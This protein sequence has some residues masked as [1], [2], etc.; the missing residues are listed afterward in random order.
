ML[1]YREL[2]QSF[3]QALGQ[4]LKNYEEEQLQKSSQI[5]PHRQTDIN[6]ILCLIDSNIDNIQ[7]LK[8]AIKAQLKQ[9]KTGIHVFHLFWIQT[10]HSK[11]KTAVIEVLNDTNHDEA[12][13]LQAQAR[14]LSQTLLKWPSEP[15]QPKPIQQVEDESDEFQL[16]ST[17]L[18]QGQNSTP[19]ASINSIPWAFKDLLAPIDFPLL[20]RDKFQA[21]ELGDEVFEQIEKHNQQSLIHYQQLWSRL[22]ELFDENEQLRLQNQR[23]AEKNQQ[24]QQI[25]SGLQAAKS[26]SGSMEDLSKMNNPHQSIK[27]AFFSR[28]SIN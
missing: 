27:A 12:A 1:N 8:V 10:G 24:L 9:C 6:A 4:A 22:E 20:Q 16:F 3:K 11:L 28:E 17:L 21:S 25:N 7:T 13:F 15:S 26:A 5:K 19:E 23:L 14:S 18:D 2:L